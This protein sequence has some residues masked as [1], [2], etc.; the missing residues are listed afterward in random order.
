ME[1]LRH[2]HGVTISDK[3]NS[4]EICKSLN[5]AQLLRKESFQLRCS[6]MRSEWHRK[7]WRSD[8]GLLHTQESGPEVNQVLF[9][10]N[11]ISS[12]LGSRLDVEP[13]EQSKVAEHHEALHAFHYLLSLWPSRNTDEN[14]CLKS[15]LSAQY[16]ESCW[17]AQKDYRKNQ[18]SSYF[19]KSLVLVCLFVRIHTS[20]T[21]RVNWRVLIFKRLLLEA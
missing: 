13:A 11:T 2:V 16:S 20:I 10:V 12:S 3:V 21:E 14:A 17:F 4:F 6:A 7:D 9:G 15:D 8:C 18:R 1:F 19:L 5:V